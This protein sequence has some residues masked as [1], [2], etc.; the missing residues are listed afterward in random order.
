MLAFSPCRLLPRR[1][2]L[3]LGGGALAALLAARAPLPA[4]ASP[5][6]LD[7]QR[8]IVRH[9][10]VIGINLGDEPLVATLYAPTLAGSDARAATGQGPAGMPIPLGAFRRALPGI[11]ATIADL[12]AEGDL[13]AARITWR[14]PHPPAGTH[15]VGQTMH[16]FR[17][18][19]DQIT[20]QWSAG[21][22]WLEARGVHT[23]CT[24]P[25]PLLT[26]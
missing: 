11:I 24:P 17:V 9:L 4:A 15:I 18:E 2:A 5:S 7:R 8:E 10:F 23:L 3:Q 21:W 6:P 25:N 22:E 19:Q 20:A 14:G 16:L 1:E 13:V 12:V 26:P